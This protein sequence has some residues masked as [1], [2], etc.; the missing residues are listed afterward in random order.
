MRRPECIDQTAA[1][2]QVWLT[3]GGREPRWWR[4]R[5]S[6]GRCP[7]E[8]RMFARAERSAQADAAPVRLAGHLIDPVQPV[9][10]PYPGDSRESR[11]NGVKPT[12]TWCR[13]QTGPRQWFRLIKIGDG[14]STG[15]PGSNTERILDTSVFARSRSQIGLAAGVQ[16]PVAIGGAGNTRCPTMRASASSAYPDGAGRAQLHLRGVGFGLLR[17]LGPQPASAT[18]GRHRK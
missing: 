3:A 9:E 2:S 12:T 11:S 13:H 4:T 18:T 5:S 1:A 8:K 10:A 6:A 7:S 15:P 17:S 14:V 16:Q